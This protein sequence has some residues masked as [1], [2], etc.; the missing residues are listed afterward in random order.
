[1]DYNKAFLS[2]DTV[3]GAL[4][5]TTENRVSQKQAAI[6]AVRE[7]GLNQI[8]EI[9]RSWFKDEK[10]ADMFFARLEILKSVETKGIL[11]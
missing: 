7:I 2:Y 8:K 10:V 9:D 5:Q 3:E 6:D 1:M 11:K 4:C